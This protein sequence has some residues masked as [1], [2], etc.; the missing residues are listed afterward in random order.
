[1]DAAVSTRVKKVGKLSVKVITD[2]SL[3]VQDKI[4]TERDA[5]MDSRATA[6]VRSAI[7]KAKICKKP[8][9]KYDTVTKKAYV[10]YAD[11]AKKYVN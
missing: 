3:S 4:I 10:E 2:D 7:D 8:I 9:A 1:V 6:A 5:E 11:G